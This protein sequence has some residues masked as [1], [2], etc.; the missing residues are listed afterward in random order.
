MFFGGGYPTG[1]MHRR[2]T[3]HAN[4][5]QQNAH[6]QNSQGQTQQQSVGDVLKFSPNF[7]IF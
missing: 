1:Q 4:F 2:G 3:R 7:S 5:Y 6:T